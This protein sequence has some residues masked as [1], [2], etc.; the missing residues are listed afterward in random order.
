MTFVFVVGCFP[1][2]QS[3]EGDLDVDGIPD[4]LEAPGETY[5]GMPVY[6]WGARPDQTDLFV[7]IDYMDPTDGGVVPADEGLIPR[8]EALQKVVDAF[9]VQG[10]ALHFDVGDL[11]DRSLD[12][13]DNPA[14]FDLGGGEEVPYADSIGLGVT[15]TQSHARTDY[16]ARYMDE[17]RHSL[18]YYMLFGSTQNTDGSPGSGGAGEIANRIS[19]VTLGGWGLNS[20]TPLEKNLLVNMQ[21]STIMHEFGHNLGL[22]HGGHEDT[23]FKPNYTSVMNY[24]YAIEGLPNLETSDEGDRYYLLIQSNATDAYAADCFGNH[25]YWP[26][27]LSNSPFAEAFFIDY[28]HGLNQEIDESQVEESA[29]IGANNGYGVDFDCD[30]WVETLTDFDLNRDGDIGKLNDHNDWENLFFYFH[31]NWGVS[32]IDQLLTSIEISEEPPPPAW[33]TDKSLRQR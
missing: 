3:V 14:R 22:R 10:I 21:A 26:D 17:D 27:T 33:V 1:V 18:F 9:A 11:F 7:E 6:E 15:D 28:S 24:L 25:P 8:E 29:G 4:N 31:Y 5:L 20:L 23:N 13:N 30:A 19:L 2:A 12:A 32:P 16:S